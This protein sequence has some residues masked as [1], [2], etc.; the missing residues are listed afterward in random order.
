ML[1]ALRG[2][3]NKVQDLKQEKKAG[4]PISLKK[5]TEIPRVHK[6]I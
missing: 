4:K 2:N 1:L 3:I 6:G 5:V